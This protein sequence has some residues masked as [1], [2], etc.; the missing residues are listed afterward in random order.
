MIHRLMLIIACG[1]ALAAA[2]PARAQD[3]TEKALEK[4]RQM[5]KE[6]PWSNPALLDAD[7][8]EAL[9][10]T[11]ARAEPGHAGDSA[12]SA[13]ARASWTARSPSCHAISPTPTA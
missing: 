7:R 11:A 2:A 4:Y 9:W 1:V 13:R 10:K 3:D 12:T 8:G 5:L 6:D